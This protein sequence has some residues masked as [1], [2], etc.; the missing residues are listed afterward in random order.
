MA[1][2]ITNKAETGAKE[3]LIKKDHVKIFNLTN[4]KN[5]TF[6]KQSRLDA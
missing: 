3:H 1:I 4:N 6:K 5:S 2:F